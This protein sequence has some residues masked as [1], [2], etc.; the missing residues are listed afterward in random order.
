MHSPWHAIALFALLEI[1]L[2][3]ATISLAAQRREDQ[4]RRSSVQ[5]W[6]NAGWYLMLLGMIVW[7]F[8]TGMIDNKSI[9]LRLD[10]P[11]RSLVYG[12]LG[13]AVVQVAS[14]LLQQFRAAEYRLS[15]FVRLQRFLW[16]RSRWGRLGVIVSLCLNPIT[17]EVMT[18]G[19]MVVLLSTASGSV[20]VGVAVGMAICLLN[21]LYQ[22]WRSLPGHAIYFAVTAILAFTE[23]GLGAAIVC[24]FIA[25]L[26]PVVRSREYMRWIRFE[27]VRRRA[28]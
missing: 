24:H 7:A 12:W 19:V 9:G 13:W 28:A 21:H 26:T 25:D 6:Q 5:A 18:R 2:L 11:V 17:E 3:I 8:C 15:E 20:A 1:P 23:G 22:G 4:P 14:M 10:S 27:R 16:P